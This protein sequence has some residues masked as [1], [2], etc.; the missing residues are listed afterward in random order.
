MVVNLSPKIMFSEKNVYQKSKNNKKTESI[1]AFQG[2]INM[3]E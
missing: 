1:I 3:F 2:L